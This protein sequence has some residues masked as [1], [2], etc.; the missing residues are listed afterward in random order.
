MG[1]PRG[2]IRSMQPGIA[3]RAP[4]KPPASVPGRRA[5]PGAPVTLSRGA[6]RAPAPT[7]RARAWLIAYDSSSTRGWKC[8]GPTVHWGNRRSRRTAA[9]R[10]SSADS[11]VTALG[12]RHEGVRHA[13]SEDRDGEVFEQ[14]V[15]VAGGVTMAPK[16]SG[17]APLFPTTDSIRTVRAQRKVGMR[18][19]F[20]VSRLPDDLNCRPEQD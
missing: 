2:Y 9:P 20:S 7:P 13:R 19:H 1:A 16:A 17:L 6:L 12:C 14:G 18:E 15:Y 4:A 5:D 3:D 10:R 8:S 11:G